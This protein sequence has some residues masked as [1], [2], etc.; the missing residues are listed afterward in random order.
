MEDIEVDQKIEEGNKEDLVRH[1]CDTF[2]T[3]LHKKDLSKKFFNFKLCR[4]IT[5][6][7]PPLVFNK[8]SN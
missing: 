3:Q 6:K 7:R 4:W 2:K 1:P 8:I 5:K